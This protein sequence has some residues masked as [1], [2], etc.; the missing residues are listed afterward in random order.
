MQKIKW[1]KIKD[2][3]NYLISNEGMIYNSKKGGIEYVKNSI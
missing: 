2:F 3:E 1:K